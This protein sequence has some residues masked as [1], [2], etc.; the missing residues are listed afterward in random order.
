MFCKKILAAAGIAAAVASAEAFAAPATGGLRTGS[1]LAISQRSMA[2][3]AAP[4][5][6]VRGGMGLQM[7]TETLP[8]TSSAFPDSAPSTKRLTPATACMSARVAALHPA[9]RVSE[10]GPTTIRFFCYTHPR[11]A[12]ALVPVRRQE[13]SLVCFVVIFSSRHE[14]SI[15][16]TSCC[17]P[18]AIAARLRW[19]VMLMF[20][21]SVALSPAEMLDQ[22]DV[23]IFDC[24]G[25]I[26]KGDS[27]RLSA[28]PYL[29]SACS[30]SSPD[31]QLNELSDAFR[32][33][34]FLPLFR[35]QERSCAYTDLAFDVGAGN[36]QP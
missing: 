17:C 18:V 26:W 35:H 20:R 30:K 16:C 14:R 3:R 1:V 34:H 33:I 19:V 2:G 27:V 23:F 4:A 6:R 28:S 7:S 13:G 5:L 15:S 32:K 36:S 31:R 21:P 10:R 12:C 11:A 25:V 22:V 24:D 8:T 9:A 29:S